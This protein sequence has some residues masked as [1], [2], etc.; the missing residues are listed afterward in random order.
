[1]LPDQLGYPDD[2]EVFCVALLGLFPGKT[3]QKIM[4]LQEQQQ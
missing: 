2:D 3:W 1:M 4:A